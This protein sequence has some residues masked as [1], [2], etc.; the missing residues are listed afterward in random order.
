MKTVKLGKSDI[1]IS[2]I[3]LG[4]MTWGQ[5]NSRAQAFEQ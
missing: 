3:C 5:Q 1:D 4:S 2:E